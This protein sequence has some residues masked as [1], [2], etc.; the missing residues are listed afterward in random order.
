MTLREDIMGTFGKWITGLIIL[1]IIALIL[2]LFTPW[3]SK[4]RSANMGQSIRNALDAANHQSV[5]LDMV[6]NVA[7]LSGSVPS[8]DI[9][10]SAMDTAQNAK[11]E[12]CA[13]RKDGDRWHEVDGSDLTIKKAIL[14]VSPYTLTGERTAD[15]GVVLN[16]YAASDAERDAIIAEAEVLF[17]GGVVDNKIKIAPGAPYAGWDNVAKAYL[18]GLSQL[19]SGEFAM[20]NAD[21]YLTGLTESTEVRAGINDMINALPTGYSGATN[22]TVPDAEAEN[23]GQ[24][25]S[26]E[27]CQELFE[28]LKGDNKINFAYNRAEVQGD[29]SMALIRT[30]ASAAVQCSSFRISVEGHTDAD[31]SEAY[32]LDLS[33]RRA[34]EVVKNLVA[35]GV[36]INTITGGGYGES[37]PIA[38]NDTPEGM[39]KNRRIEFKVTRSK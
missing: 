3:G 30:L 17:P 16:G 13:D 7:K 36:D 35:N 5:N 33:R 31:G 19:D 34:E 6:G 1:G 12:K 38:S 24:I 25:K 37:R 9:K 4:A 11:C 23:T 21:S 10:A 39:A 8:E 2:E 27:I 29:A 15:N 18:D 22:I 28:K 20:N 26:E 14:S 32:N